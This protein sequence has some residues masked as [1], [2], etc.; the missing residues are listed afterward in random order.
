MACCILHNIC[1]A[2]GDVLDDADSATEETDDNVASRRRHAVAKR[3]GIA[4]AL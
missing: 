2:N 1:I 4:Q 3:D